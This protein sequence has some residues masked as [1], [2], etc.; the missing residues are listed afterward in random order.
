MTR[1]WCQVVS[2]IARWFSTSFNFSFN[3]PQFFLAGL[4]VSCFGD[5]LSYSTWYPTQAAPAVLI[6]LLLLLAPPEYILV[7]V[8][9]LQNSTDLWISILHFVWS[10]IQ[11][12]EEVNLPPEYLLPLLP[13]KED[14][15]PPPLPPP[16]LV[17][18]R[19]QEEEEETQCWTLSHWSRVVWDKTNFP[20][21]HS[22]L[23]P[24]P[25][26]PKSESP[27]SPESADNL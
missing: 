27:W 26:H 20:A 2:G 25:I 23:R 21:Q 16:L 19:N 8:C 10:N 18:V 3:S 12:T 14:L 1:V 24:P 11:M 13:P 7:Y 22:F 5:I 4:S 9:W 6:R 17:M 15:P